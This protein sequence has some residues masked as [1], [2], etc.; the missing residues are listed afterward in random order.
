MTENR[1]R[2]GV[3]AL[4]A[5]GMAWVESAVVL[6]LRTLVH[7][8]E[9]YQFDPLPLAAGFAPVEMV[10]EAATVLML[11]SVGWLAGGNLRSRLGYFVAAF[12]IWDIFY[13]VFLRL[14]CGWPHSLLDWDVLFLLPLP[15]WGPVIAPCLI[16]SLMILFG[17]WMSVQ[18]YDSSRSKTR[19]A[20][21]SLMGLGVLAALILFMKDAIGAI[22]EP[23]AAKLVGQLLPVEFPWAPFL[24]A[25]GLMASPLVE[26]WAGRRRNSVKADVAVLAL[27]EGNES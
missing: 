8:I 12:G 20:T 4:Y 5:L 26:A 24:A 2:F 19:M 17:W 7:R 21:W 22:G 23:N 9:P 27:G 13:Y 6:Y 11:A 16:A 10:R 15:W 3:V 14:M 18:S 25:L 1:K